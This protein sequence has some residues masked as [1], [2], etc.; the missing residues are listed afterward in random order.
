MS[1]SS[2]TLQKE[3]API[4]TAICIKRLWVPHSLLRLVFSTNDDFVSL[5]I[6]THNP[7]TSGDG[8]DIFGYHTGGEGAA[9]IL[10]VEA[11]DAVEHLTML[12]IELSRPKCQ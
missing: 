2:S 7:R 5:P 10:R 12:R 6:P 8:W 3:K 9:S 11:R 1:N 4:M